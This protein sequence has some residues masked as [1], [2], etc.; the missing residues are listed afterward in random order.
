MAETCLIG[1]VGQSLEWIRQLC[2]VVQGPYRREYEQICLTH[3]GGGELGTGPVRRVGRRLASRLL[4]GFDRLHRLSRSIGRS[5]YE[6]PPNGPQPPRIFR[7]CRCAWD[8][9]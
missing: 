8:P 7:M 4:T 3:L 2:Q 5:V 1:S 9:R 6:K